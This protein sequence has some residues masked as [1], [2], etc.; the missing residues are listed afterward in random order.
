MSI[1][2]AE[3]VVASSPARRMKRHRRYIN[4]DREAA[5]FRLWHGYFNDDCVYHL[6][7][8]SDVLYVDDSFP[9]HYT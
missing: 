1:L 3:E 8:S 9:K 5:H 2:Q 6:I 4:R 7:L